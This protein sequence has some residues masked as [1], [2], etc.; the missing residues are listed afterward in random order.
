MTSTSARPRNDIAS[1]ARCTSAFHADAAARAGAISVGERQVLDG[2][3]RSHES[4]VLV[5]EAD[6][7]V[8]GRRAVAERQ[9][10]PVGPRSAP[11]SGWW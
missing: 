5:D 1:R 2:V 11:G 9:R 7:G 10:L 6:A 4:E 8:C 3:E